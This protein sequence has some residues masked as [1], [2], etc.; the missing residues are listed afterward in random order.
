MT[1]VT[2]NEA[3]VTGLGAIVLNP[4]KPRAPRHA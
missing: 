3:D 4:F 1:L 2:R